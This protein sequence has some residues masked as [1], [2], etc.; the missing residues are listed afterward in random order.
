MIP[1]PIPP[2]ESTQLGSELRRY[3][4]SLF[5]K[6]RTGDLVKALRRPGSFLF[7]RTNT[8]RITNEELVAALAEEGVASQICDPILNAVGIPIPPARPVPRH[9]KIAVAD[10]PSSENVMLGSHLFRPGVLQTSGFREGE[11]VTIVNPLGHVV[12]S[13]V[14]ACSSEELHAR[15]QGL[16]IRVTNPLYPLPSLSDLSAYKAGL[17]YSQSLPAMLVSHTLDPQPGETIIDFCAAPGGKTT[18]IAQLVGN[19]CRLVAVDRSQRRMERLLDETRR[20]GV[21]CVEPFIGKAKEFCARYPDFQ[22]DRVVVDPPCTALGVRPKLYDTTTLARIHSTASYQR[23][24]LDSAVEALRPGGV[25]VYSTCTLTV[26][27]NE[28]NILYLVSEKGFI[29]EEQNPHLGAGGPVEGL[30]RMVQRFYPPR[31]PRLL[32]RPATQTL[33]HPLTTPLSR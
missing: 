2:P 8:L 13:G 27:E 5:G 11:L 30:G 3:F 6:T 4:L 15:K 19:R 14:A 28:H 25:L 17:F 32:H 24:I 18:H 21:T 26:E 16:V 29:L 9:E 22:A 7:L 33:I 31:P 23:M 1:S 12:G 10:K 20:L